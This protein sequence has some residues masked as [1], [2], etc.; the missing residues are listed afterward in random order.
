MSLEKASVL[1]DAVVDGDDALDEG[2]LEVDALGKRAV[3]HLAHR[4]Q[5]AG[6]AD[7]HRRERVDAQHAD[8]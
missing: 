6:G 1:L 3:L 7:R 4:Q 5:D 8:D 2:Q